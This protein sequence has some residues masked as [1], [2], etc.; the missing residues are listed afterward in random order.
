VTEAT[1]QSKLIESLHAGLPGAKW[2]TKHSDR[3]TAGIPDVS[4]TWRGGTTWLELKYRRRGE[5]LATIVE[6]IQV[7]ECIKLWA[8]S[9]GRVVFTVYDVPTDSTILYS[10]KTMLDVFRSSEVP[11]VEPCNGTLINV[12]EQVRER[13]LCRARGFDHEFVARFISDLDTR[14]RA[15]YA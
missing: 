4:V 5:K 7:S 6:P 2:I 10:P 9:R 3:S 15:L 8:A 14:N 1:I 13:G 12:A 11:T